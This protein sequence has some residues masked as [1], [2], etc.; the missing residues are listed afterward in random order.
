M[1]ST[2]LKTANQ[3][4]HP[5]IHQSALFPSGVKSILDWSKTYL[6]AFQKPGGAIPDPRQSQVPG[7]HGIGLYS[8]NHFNPKP[9]GTNIL[10]NDLTQEESWTNPL[11]GILGLSIFL[12][13]P[14]SSITVIFSQTCPA[15][16]QDS[17]T[18]QM[19]EFVWLVYCIPSEILQ[20]WRSAYYNN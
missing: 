7:N 14:D 19:F 20:L 4:Q 17:N 18:H 3:C 15:W 6:G 8:M 10:A 2:E 9:N 16:P 5:W 1:Q 13:Q 11:P 12:D